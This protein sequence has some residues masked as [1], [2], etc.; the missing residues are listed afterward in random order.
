MSTAATRTVTRET[1]SGVPA[2]KPGLQVLELTMEDILCVVVSSE[3]KHQKAPPWEEFDTYT[4]HLAVRDLTEEEMEEYLSVEKNRKAEQK[5]QDDAHHALSL[6][7]DEVEPDAIPDGVTLMEAHTVETLGTP[8]IVG[9]I[10]T[11]AYVDEASA[12]V[13]LLT[14]GTDD[15]QAI[16]EGEEAVRLARIFPRR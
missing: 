1:Y 6:F 14:R 12:T 3:T 16:A 11:T 7:S 5:R 2:A 4:E 8:G 10:S 15:R 13:Y 9:S